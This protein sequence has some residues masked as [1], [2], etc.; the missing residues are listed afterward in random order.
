MNYCQLT[1]CFKY[2]NSLIFKKWVV[3]KYSLQYNNYLIKKGVIEMESILNKLVLCLFCLIPVS[4]SLLAKDG[5]KNFRLA[6]YCPVRDVKKMAD[7]GWL[8]KNYNLLDK[9]LDID[10]VY[11]ETFRSMDMVDK[12]TMLKVKKFFDDRG[13][14]T[15]G[16]ITFCR[17]EGHQFESFC[18]TNDEHR[19]KIKEI[20]EY[21]ASM[22]DEI[23][24]DDFWFANTKWESSI[25]AKG[26]KSWTRFRLDIM[27]E[28]SRKLIIE[29]IKK[30]NSNTNIIIKYP[31]WYDHFQ[32]CGYDLE[33]ESKIFDMIYTGTETRDPVYTHQHLQPYQSY[34]IMR[35]FENVAPGRNGGGWVDPF[36][37]RY[38]DRYAEQLSLTMFAKPKEMTLFCFGLLLESIIEEDGSS[39]PISI[40]AP[41]A[42]YSL[43]KADAFLDKLGNP[44]GIKCYKPYNSYGEDF[45]P[46]Y[47]G[48][49]GI[50]VDIT[51]EFPY[52]E[53]MV[54]LTEQASFDKDII[55]KIKKQLINGKEVMIT[56]GLYKA[57][58]GKGIEDIV[59]LE[60]TD[61]K[62]MVHKFYDWRDV[63]VS[64]NDI[65]IPEIRYATNDSWELL[66]ALDGE[67]GYPIL[68]QA[69]YGKGKLYVLVIPENFGEL[70]EFPKEVLS[71]IKRILMK[72]FYVTVKSPSKIS[73]F[74][75]DNNTF[76]VH[77]FK[78]HGASIQIVL[79]KKFKNLVEIQSNREI[80]GRIEGNNTVFDS[81]IWPHSYQ[82]FKAE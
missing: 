79:D 9:Y 31:N 27:E 5:Y 43:E 26:K 51:P 45:L 80:Q 66:T 47:I 41:V 39:K 36:A 38:L 23:I 59:E 30:I 37:R 54:F 77:S 76:I 4:L 49:L 10:K 44:I 58:Q 32:N 40:I 62:T 64:E 33:R 25:K 50:P 48:M 69:S 56:S 78:D 8:E 57:L 24:L 17:K 46:N 2:P 13:I 11:L 18:L 1:F 73:L 70:Y 21:T 55:K 65:M 16:G 75:Y 67:V 82:V 81:Y 7:L 19:K 28:A 72:N 3:D 20:S 60:Y 68:Q 42:G 52:D 35:Y 53:K 14:E 6:I 29:P 74:A 22:F 34:A 61:K 63:Y 71:L 15:S 12:K